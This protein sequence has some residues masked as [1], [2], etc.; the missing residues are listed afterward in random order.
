MFRK[1]ALSLQVVTIV[2]LL[3]SQ[4]F[5]QES[6]EDEQYGFIEPAVEFSTGDYGTDED[7]D[8]FSIP[9]TV[10]Y[11]P[12]PRLE[13]YVTFV[14]FMYMKTTNLLAVA[15][16]PVVGMKGHGSKH[17]LPPDD[18]E[19]EDTD[20]DS[21]TGIGDTTVGLS[22]YLLE[23]TQTLPSIYFSGSIKLPT[24]DED[25]YLGTG[26]FD[27]IVE[28]GASKDFGPWGLFGSVEYNFIGD[29]GGDYDLDDYAGITLG[30]SHR[31]FER[32]KNSLYIY[33]AEAISD[34]SDDQLEIGFKSRFSIDPRNDISAFVARGLQDGSPDWQLGLYWSWYF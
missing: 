29:P 21:E 19:Q 33:A 31:S 4:A 34:E 11:S 13:L 22:Y 7:T 15:G 3:T 2:L 30:I 28:L 23:Q 10:G 1:T 14:P 16:R 25:K 17:T 24:A 27:Y 8:L 32:L 9:I 18:T 6:Q 26:E 12:I 5:S 20:R